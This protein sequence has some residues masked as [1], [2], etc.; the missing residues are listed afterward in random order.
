MLAYLRAFGDAVFPLGPDVFGY[1]WQTRLVGQAPLSVIE[2][3]PGVPVLGSV[4]AGSGIISDR[5]ATFVLAPVLIVALGFAVAISVRLAFRLP[6]WA[7]GVVGF[8]VALWGG[9]LNL[10]QGHVANLLSVVCIVPAILLVAI[11]SGS[12]PVQTIGAIAAIT[13]SGLAHAGTL[14]FFAATGLLWVV[15]SV[16]SIARARRE[17]SRWWREP[18][19]SFTFA[20]VVASTIVAVAIIGLFGVGVEDFT[21]IDD[22]V[23]SFATRLRQIVRSVG[24]WVTPTTVLASIGLVAVWRLARPSSRALT[25]FGLALSIVSIVGALIAAVDP[26]VPGHRALGMILPIP[27]LAGLGIVGL[28]LAVIAGRSGQNS[29][30]SVRVVRILV[31]VGVVVAL[32]ALVVSPGLQRLAKRARARPMGKPAQAI[33]SYVAAVEPAG[34]VVVFVDPATKLD[35]LSWR[36]RQNQIRALAP[37]PFV[38]RIFVLVGRLGANGQP[39]KAVA[40]GKVERRAFEYAVEQSWSAGGAALRDDAVVLVPRS[41]VSPQF[42]NQV[43]SDPSRVVMPSLAVLRGPLESPE[44]LVPMARLRVEEAVGRIIIALLALALLGAGYGLSIA[45]NRGGS[46]LDGIGLAPSVGA[47]LV[48]LAGV[49]VAAI[50]SDPGGPFGLAVVGLGSGVGYLIAWRRWR[51]TMWQG[52]HVA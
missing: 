52:R 31:A 12:W 34:P 15:L 8:G 46:W 39:E 50:G 5:A 43:T 40:P 37:A 51:R 35:A 11:P 16:P 22:R 7:I 38:D 4:L 49:A 18:S 20:L 1:I 2:A 26:M 41:H 29:G 9:S 45:G 27:T 3:R 32:S 44:G 6:G 21:N 25:R 23:F 17:G 42:W 24:L 10:S 33:A 47:I 48:V 36:G 14:P 13:A 28:A 30:R 19:C